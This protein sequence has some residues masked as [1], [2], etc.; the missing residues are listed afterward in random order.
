MYGEYETPAK[1]HFLWMMWFVLAAT[2]VVIG[3]YL[4]GHAAS[5][6]NK[7]QHQQQIECLERGGE[8]QRINGMSGIYCNKDN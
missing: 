6:A 8:M 7:A 4:I 5:D 1:K 2:F 3:F